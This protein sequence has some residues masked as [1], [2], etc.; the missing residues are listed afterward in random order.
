MTRSRF[1]MFGAKTRITVEGDEAGCRDYMGEVNRAL[2]QLQRLTPP[3]GCFALPERKYEDG[4]TI[5]VWAAGGFWYAHVFKPISEENPREVVVRGE[6]WYIAVYYDVYQES[7]YSYEWGYIIFDLKDFKPVEKSIVYREWQDE[8]GWHSENYPE[9]SRAIIWV[10]VEGD[11]G[12]FEWGG[13]RV[14]THL[15][16]ETPI[17]VGP[18][19][20][21]WWYDWAVAIGDPD[22]ESWARSEVHTFYAGEYYEQSVLPVGLQFSTGAKATTRM[23]DYLVGDPDTT[24]PNTKTVSGY[25]STRACR[26][27]WIG[28]R[29]S[30]DPVSYNVATRYTPWMQEYMY[31]TRYTAWS[32]NVY[33]GADQQA[34]GTYYHYASATERSY[35]YAEWDVRSKAA[36]DRHEYEERICYL[37]DPPEVDFW[38]Y[39]DDAK[40]TAAKTLYINGK[41]QEEIAQYTETAGSG[42]LLYQLGISASPFSRKVEEDLSEIPSG[43]FG[44][45]TYESNP[46]KDSY[47]WSVANYSNAHNELDVFQK[48]DQLRT[49]TIKVKTPYGIAERTFD[50][51]GEFFGA[52]I[53]DFPY[54]YI[55]RLKRRPRTVPI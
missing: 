6:E 13:D 25:C 29:L 17:P 39:G 27:H 38:V 4:T 2:Y 22:P 31:S 18:C 44:S 7:P 36:S 35:M 53:Y 26:W 11:V 46:A 47:L 14:Y 49:Y 41:A 30:N 43:G 19:W 40:A 9:E 23:R 51:G 12:I 34:M 1:P 32:R 52:A 24:F 42:G 10:A 37:A 45:A 28:P 8:S 3:G 33:T 54:A 21:Q 16:E 5:K 48:E 55:C 20:D 50:K 15:K